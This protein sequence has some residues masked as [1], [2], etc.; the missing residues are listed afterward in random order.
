M[1]EWKV[2][3]EIVDIKPHYN[4][5]N[6][7]IA[8]VGESQLVVQ[9]GDYK[10][11]DILVF[12]ME[13]SILPYELAEKFRNYLV[14]PEK[15]RVKAIRLR[16]E[17]SCGIALSLEEAEK[18]ATDPIL[19]DSFGYG[20][21]IS[22]IFNITKYEPP[23]PQQLKGS[24]KAMGHTPYWQAHDCYHLAS[25]IH[26]FDDGEEIV[27]SE[28]IHGS[29]V[30][31]FKNE[32]GEATL[33][34][35]GLAKRSLTIEESNTNTYWQAARATGI[36]EILDE[37]YPN[38]NVQVYGEVVPV[39]SGFSYGFSSPWLFV[40]RMNV[41][42]ENIPYREVD[43]KIAQFWVPIL[44]EGPLDKKDLSYIRKLAKGTEEV[45]GTQK[46]IKEGV[47]INPINFRL[48]G[49]GQPLFAKFLNPKYKEDDTAIN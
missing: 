39:Q 4:A 37:L 23:I 35:K 7:E 22:H 49:K 20:E 21:D 27:V 16:G 31:L 9:K 34:S 14:G 30:Y 11:G 6:L 26:S 19:I 25:M 2:S 46:H 36:F 47:V 44:Y 43:E 45:S 38:D 12:I 28:K 32:F 40:Y 18:F 33:T 13:K 10:T 48:T 29:L 24:T 17:Y 1:A 5:N 3:K 42:G 8:L 41:N 15:N